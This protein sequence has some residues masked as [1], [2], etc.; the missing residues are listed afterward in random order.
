LY[1]RCKDCNE[2][3][4]QQTQLAEHC[5]AVH[6]NAIKAYVCDGNSLG[7]GRPRKRG[8]PPAKPRSLCSTFCLFVTI[9]GRSVVGTWKIMAS[10]LFPYFAPPVL[11]APYWKLNNKCWFNGH[12]QWAPWSEG[13][14]MNFKPKFPI[15]LQNYIVCTYVEVFRN[16]FKFLQK[17]I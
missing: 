8:R 12:R 3:F 6:G 11:Y 9:F 4:T 16:F 10:C 1:F 2:T 13:D 14:K 17:P 5:K 7:V 15:K